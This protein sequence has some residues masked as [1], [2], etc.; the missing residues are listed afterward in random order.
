MVPHFPLLM[1]ANAH[2]ASRHGAA[3]QHEPFLL[4]FRKVRNRV[5]V[6]NRTLKQ[7]SRAGETAPLMTDRRQGNPVHGGRVPDVLVFAAIK[8]AEAFGGRPVISGSMR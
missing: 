5:V 4:I 1:G 3:K 7:S 2:L 8:T 6:F